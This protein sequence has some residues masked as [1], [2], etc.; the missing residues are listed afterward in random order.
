MYDHDTAIS[1][2]FIYYRAEV[3]LDDFVLLSDSL[4]HQQG[5][6]NSNWKSTVLFLFCIVLSLFWHEMRIFMKADRASFVSQTNVSAKCGSCFQRTPQRE[7]ALYK[8]TSDL[9]IAEYPWQCS[10]LIPYTS[11]F[12]AKE[13]MRE[14]EMERWYVCVCTQQ[15][16]FTEAEINVIYPKGRFSMCCR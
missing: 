11:A 16:G 8:V 1:S 14:G 13:R 12:G 4:S 2:R 10:D 7:T 6:F 3:F 9:L 15:A 5:R